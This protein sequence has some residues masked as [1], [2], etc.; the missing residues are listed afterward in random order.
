VSVMPRLARWYSML[1]PV[2]PPPTTATL[3]RKKS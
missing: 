1:E 2:E 3:V